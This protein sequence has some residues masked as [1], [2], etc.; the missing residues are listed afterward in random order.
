MFGAAKLVSELRALDF[1]AEIFRG[2]DDQEYVV[3][4]NY[5]VLVGRFIG[6]V[7]ELAVFPMADYPRNVASAIHVKADPQL[8]ETKDS[9]PNVRNITDSAIGPEWRYW[10]HNFN[11]TTER[12]A[13]RLIS[14]INTIFNNA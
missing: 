6:R 3:I 10:S 5:E 7:I 13:R 1:D 11:W 2:A 12:D 4:H 9:V 14:Q 8:F